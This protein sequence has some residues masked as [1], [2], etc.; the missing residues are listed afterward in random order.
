MSSIWE[1][2]TSRSSDLVA[3]IFPLGKDSNSNLLT[4]SLFHPLLLLS[5]NLITESAFVNSV[6]SVIFLEYGELA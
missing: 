6:F 1:E 4:L 2:T 3:K 5:L